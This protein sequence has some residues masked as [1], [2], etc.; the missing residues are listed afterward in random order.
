MFPVTVPIAMFVGYLPRFG[1]AAGLA[2]V[3]ATPYAG[4]RGRCGRSN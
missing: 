2:A 1:G 4:I 3:A